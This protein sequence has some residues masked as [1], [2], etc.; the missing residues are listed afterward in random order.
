MIL[1]RYFIKE[2]IYPF[3]LTLGIIAAILVMDQVYK[4]MPFMQLTGLKF[5]YLAEALL[6]GL[7][8]NLMIATPVSIMVGVYFGVHRLSMDHEIVIMR[9]AGVSLAFLFRPVLVVAGGLAI[10]SGLNCFFLAPWGVTNLE[11]LQ[12][13]ILKTETNIKLNPG[14]INNFF[15]QK[16]IFI[17]H[18]QKD[19]LEGIV[20][21]PWKKV[22]SASLIEAKKGKIAFNED[23]RKITFLLYEGKIHRKEKGR[24]RVM[25][26][27]QLD[28]ALSPPK[29]DAA[30]LPK[31]FRELESK[32]GK[33]DMEM[34]PLELMEQMNSA[35]TASSRR[36]Y[37]DEFHSRIVTVLSCFA[38]AL[39]A[40]PLGIF[41]PRNP[42]SAKFVSM[43]LFMVLYFSLFSQARSLYVQ[44]SIGVWA[45]YFPLFIALGV[46][47]ANFF[48][49]NYDLASLTELWRL[50]H[51]Q[52]KKK[53]EIH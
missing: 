47:V 19:W 7:P 35:P 39:F 22:D 33:K 16:M 9:A 34:F 25:E 20:I 38:F 10:W 4:F 53:H 36:E 41:D 52:K 45:L 50:K 26:F 24:I 27:S 40:L 31:R 43:L 42:K 21:A 46:G 18:K 51:L 49:I 1:F 5:G 12:F 23:S 17:H 48:K 8:P 15:G 6:Y 28:Y 2:L 30:N 29:R 3:L 37:S 13:Q 44:G 14:K 11:A 32:G